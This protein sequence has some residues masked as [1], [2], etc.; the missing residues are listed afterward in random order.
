MTQGSV[1]SPLL[2]SFFINALS[3]YLTDILRIVQTVMQTV[4]VLTTINPFPSTQNR[5]KESS[6]GHPVDCF[7]KGLSRQPG[8]QRL[9]VQHP[10]VVTVHFLLSRCEGCFS[11]AINHECEGIGDVDEESLYLEDYLNSYTD[12]N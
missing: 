9:D 2:F 5:A 11:T 8:I 3:L 12:I 7:G 10:C 1:L 6:Q 4:E